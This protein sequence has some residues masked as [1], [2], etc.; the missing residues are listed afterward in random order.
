M[1]T[2]RDKIEREIASIIH[3]DSA[4][5]K[6]VAVV[7]EL[8]DSNKMNAKQCKKVAQ[9]IFSGVEVFEHEKEI[10]SIM[11][12]D[13]AVA[14]AFSVITELFYSNNTDLGQCKK[15]AQCIVLGTEMFAL[16][17]AMREYE[18]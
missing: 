11:H 18:N 10:A 2:K 14:E 5:A 13:S 1:K 9:C 12:E 15:V 3:E 6:V 17:S 16:E 4:V 7:S 8:F